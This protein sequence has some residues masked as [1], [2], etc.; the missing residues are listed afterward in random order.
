MA[1]VKFT[2]LALKA[3]EEIA[4]YVNHVP[5]ISHPFKFKESFS[6]QIF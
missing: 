2:D 4:T 6:V 1:E 3:F 5:F